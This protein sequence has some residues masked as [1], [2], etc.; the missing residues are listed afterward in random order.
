[1]PAAAVLSGLIL[2]PPMLVLA[3][4]GRTASGVGHPDPTESSSARLESRSRSLSPEQVEG[5]LKLAARAEQV[6]RLD[7]ADAACR[8]ILD[9]DPF[10]RLARQALSDLAER[11]PLPGTSPACEQTRAVLPSRFDEF[12]TRRFVVLSDA[13]VAWTRLQAQRLERTHHQF[14]RFARRL[15]LEPLPLRH[16]LVCVLFADRDDYQHFARTHDEVADPWIAGYYSPRHDRVVFYQGDANPSV[17]EARSR[18]NQM[19]TEMDSLAREADHAARE[20]RREHAQVLRQQQQRYRDHLQRESERVNAFADQINT[21]TTVHETTHQLL[22]HTRLQSPRIQYPIWIS[23]GLATS[24]ETDDTDSAFG[25]DHEY[26][27]RREAFEEVLRDDGLVELRELV[28][29]TRLAPTDDRL[30][31]AVYQQSYALVTWMSRY[32]RD[33]LGDYL[34]RM[35][36]EPQGTISADRYRELFEQAFGDID[37]LQ[38]AWLRHERARLKP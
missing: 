35:L 9:H 19:R 4:V 3:A 33:E 2:A 16:K 15:G 36:A 38:S 24:F 25:P 22:F 28:V 11:R 10:H 21:A 8:R 1:M 18:L 12:Q 31:H 7:D 14:H 6:G 23:E 34:K 20:G 5:L 26:P 17:V 13:E 29:L 30:I 27:P 37:E 32:R